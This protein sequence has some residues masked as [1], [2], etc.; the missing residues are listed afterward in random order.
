MV[1]YWADSIWV[2]VVSIEYFL[3]IRKWL[4]LGRC[5]GIR[6]CFLK[7][8]ILATT[9]KCHEQKVRKYMEKLVQLW[10][11]KSNPDAGDD[12]LGLCYGRWMK[13]SNP[14]IQRLPPKN[15]NVVFWLHGWGPW[16]DKSNPQH[17]PMCPVMSNIDLFGRG[18]VL[19][20]TLYMH[21]FIG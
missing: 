14:I 2:E 15:F 21:V 17:Q 8:L 19:S 6:V 13:R 18:L 11:M 12:R 9:R 3:L 7:K 10:T 5:V 16:T 1:H 20:W 4:E